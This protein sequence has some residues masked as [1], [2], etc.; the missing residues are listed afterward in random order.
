MP[1]NKATTLFNKLFQSKVF[2]AILSIVFSFLLWVYYTSNYGEEITRTFP[3]VEVT[4]SGETT[5]R[6]QLSLIITQEETQTVSVTLKGSRRDLLRL[7]SD[8]ISAVV[9]LSKV[10]RAGY[11]SVA[12]T[13]SYPSYVDSTNITV[14]RQTPQTISFNVSKLSSKAVDVKGKFVGTVADGYVADTTLSF[15]PATVTITGPEEELEEVSCAYVVIDRDN[16]SASFTTQAN[17]SLVDASGNS[18]NYD[19]IECDQTTVNATLP[20]SMT[21]EVA[22]D[23]D[24]V[25]G[26]GATSTNVIKKISP[27][28]IILAGDAATLQGINKISL[29][30]ID[31]SDYQTFPATEYPIV[32]PN[33]TE[34]L[35]GVTSATVNLEFTG[36]STA[37][38][39]VTNMDYI[40]LAGGYSATV[41]P[42][43]LIVT[44]RAPEKT[45]SEISANN[46]RAVADLSGITV[47]S[48]APTSIYVDGYSDAGAVGDY[49]MWVSITPKE[50]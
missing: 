24:L 22:L 10:T 5:M 20:I 36:L 29:A 43:S 7:S 40:N 35:S 39:T 17:F 11:R 34:N 16:V 4:Y 8:D 27:A 21:K 6:E 12:Y 32:L 28:T 33:N 26:G 49:T 30:T 44:I 19:D 9:D 13:L 37:L 45:L 14:Q 47:T 38:F 42:T 2:W 31:L 50:G 3:G 15:D 18:V 1:Q 48:K 41:M 46:I 25:D 23:V